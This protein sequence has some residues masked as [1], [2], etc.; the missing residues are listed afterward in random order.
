MT[1]NQR[2]TLDAARELYGIASRLNQQFADVINSM[3][4]ADERPEQ[5]APFINDQTAQTQALTKLLYMIGTWEQT[6][7]E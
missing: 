6:W 3:M 4:D 2:Q 5:Y 7:S 1:D